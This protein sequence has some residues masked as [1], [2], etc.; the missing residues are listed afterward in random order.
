MTKI[1]WSANDFVEACGEVLALVADASHSA[2][3]GVLFIL[4]SV[5]VLVGRMQ[6]IKNLK[7][8][9]I[10]MVKDLA[11]LVCI[12]KQI[13][14]DSISNSL[15]PSIQNLKQQIDDANKILDKVDEMC[16][17]L[18]FASGLKARLDRIGV[19][20]S[21]SKA[22]LNLAIGGGDPIHFVPG[23]TRGRKACCKSLTLGDAPA[24]RC[25]LMK[26]STFERCPIVAPAYRLR[27]KNG[28][29][30]VYYACGNCAKNTSKAWWKN[31][32]VREK[33]SSGEDSSCSSDQV[34]IEQ[35]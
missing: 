9:S 23:R 15:S 10:A 32:Y 25:M 19:Q 12:L 5:N 2:P 11:A 3:M 14:V 17:P 21:N 33:V 1:T 20:I 18:L 26:K 35:V 13:T 8:L 24:N 29:E 28:V 31:D 7:I 6:D 30:V 4:N 27:S 16:C 22:T 34:Q